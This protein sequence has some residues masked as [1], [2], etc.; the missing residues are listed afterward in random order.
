LI[1]DRDRQY[2]RIRSDTDTIAKLSFSPKLWF[3]GRATLA[4]QVVNKH[5]AMRNETI[6]PSRNQLA[7]ERVG[8]NPAPLADDCSL[9]DLNERPDEGIIAD[10][11]AVQVCRLYDG[12]IFT[13]LYVNNPDRTADD[14]IHTQEF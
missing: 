2:G 3:S 6:V 14:W 9:L 5:G 11:A 7:Y 12:H 1:T 4:E 13:K 8:L 10:V